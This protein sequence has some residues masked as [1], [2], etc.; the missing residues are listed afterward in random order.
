MV[1]EATFGTPVTTATAFGEVDEEGFQESFDVLTRGDMNRYGASKAIDSKHYAD[2]S[3]SMPL[4]PDRFTMM[5]LHGLFGT[6]TPGGTP[7]TNDTLTEL[8]DTSS[9]NLPSYT[10]LVG[11]DDKEFT[12]AGQV[13]DSCS[14]SASVGEYA[15]ISFNTTGM[16]SQFNLS[17]GA[18]V[19]LASL[20][21]PTYDYTGDAA[22]FVGA[23]VNF[24]D[25]AT[26]TAYSKLVQSIS[27]DIKTN[28]DLDN[29]YNLGDSCISRVPPLGMREV[30]GTITF[31][32]NVIT[33]DIAVDEPDYINL[34][35]GDL[36]NGSA[37]NP[38]LSVLFYVGA[39]DYI[40]L[41]I[42]KLHYEAPQT[43]VSGRDSQT[44][45]V[46]FIGLYDETET[47]MA[48]IT[49]SSSSTAFTGGAKVD[50][51]A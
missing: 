17:N 18:T 24:E 20:S 49:F 7:G 6:H 33:A 4:Q 27:V 8:A 38:A 41:D 44:M 12:Y 21:A 40:R 42:H 16:K 1:K 39:A 22:H 37:S 45:S 9:A 2:G 10:F 48:K 51:D 30:T 36:I 15:M 3:F 34:L 43:S 23:Y 28:R 29:S 26:T 46:N 32:K 35:S 5:C 13:I 25:L 11:R 19:A 47:E 50:L 31:H 14:I